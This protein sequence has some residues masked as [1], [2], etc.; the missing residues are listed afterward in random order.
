MVYAYIDA[1]I[2]ENE[3]KNKT[4][5]KYRIPQINIDSSDVQAIN[6]EIIIKFTN[7]YDEMI[8]QQVLYEL[9]EYKYFVNGDILS[10]IIIYDNW[11]SAQYFSSDIY[12]INI[13]T[14]KQVNSNELLKYLNITEEEFREKLIN[15]I[16]NSPDYKEPYDEEATTKKCDETIKMYEEMPINEM[17]LYISTDGNIAAY[18]YVNAVAGGEFSYYL[19]QLETGELDWD[20]VDVTV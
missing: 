8:E 9:V 20:G 6:D 13:S 19:M 3:D 14:G 12:N 4:E 10:L 17:Q 11:M 18:I 2:I 1:R 5:Y 7:R 16:K 15:V